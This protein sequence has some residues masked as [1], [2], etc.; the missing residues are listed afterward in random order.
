MML[1]SSK[2]ISFL[3]ALCAED[4]E[5]DGYLSYVAEAV[6]KILWAPAGTWR[7]TPWIMRAA[8]LAGVQFTW[9]I[10]DNVKS[11]YCGGYGGSAL[12]E[13][14]L[15]RGQLLAW[16]RRAASDCAKH[17]AVACTVSSTGN[18]FFNR[19]YAGERREDTGKARARSMLA[20]MKN[21]VKNTGLLFGAWTGFDPK[22]FLSHAC[23]AQPAGVLLPSATAGKSTIDDTEITV[24]AYMTGATWL[25]YKGIMVR[26]PRTKKGGQNMH[27]KNKAARRRCVLQNS[28]RVLRWAWARRN[29]AQA[30]WEEFARWW[31]TLSWVPVKSS[32]VAAD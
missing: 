5:I 4:P 22:R 7:A 31:D 6:E 1:F 17:Q 28:L 20:I 21:H 14:E 9:L 26:K 30:R 24:R 32:A 3:L 29:H 15:T 2:D 27:F 23:G 25:R 10:D 19:K 16:M 18:P 12:S 11:I 8:K 13:C